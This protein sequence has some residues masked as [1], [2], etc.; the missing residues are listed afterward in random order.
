MVTSAR[1]RI[2]RHEQV[3]DHHGWSNFS[4]AGAVRLRCVNASPAAPILRKIPGCTEI[5]TGPGEVD[6][7]ATVAEGSCTL[8]DGTTL[9][10]FMWPSSD[11]AAE[12]NYVYETADTI[13]DGCLPQSVNGV[14]GGNDCIMGNT[15]GLLW[16]I[17]ID[18]TAYAPSYATSLASPIIR[19]LHGQLVTFV[20]VSWCDGNYCVPAVGTPSSAQSS[21]P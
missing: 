2:A 11:A 18:T 19:V 21:S 8:S 20:P 7:D 5:V 16:F 13:L 4:P 1:S 12:K 6:D 14:A 10:L 15:S 17:T 3:G 9:D